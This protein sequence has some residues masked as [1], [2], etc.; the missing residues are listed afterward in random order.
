[1]PEFAE[2][3]GNLLVEKSSATNG[4]RGKTANPLAP[5]AVTAERT[6]PHSNT[7]KGRSLH[8]SEDRE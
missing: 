5:V 6:S 4:S 7:L 2:L 1:V 8:F 3:D